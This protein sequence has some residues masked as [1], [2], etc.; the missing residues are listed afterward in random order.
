MKSLM[1]IVAS[2]LL[3]GCAQADAPDSATASNPATA[4]SSVR[5][6]LADSGVTITG[7]L[8]APEGFHGLVGNYRGR[9]LPVYVL[10]DGKHFVVG[11]LYDMQGNDLTSPAM[12][13]A[14][15]SRLSETQWKALDKATWFA[16]G[17][18]EGKR[19]VY[20]FM[21]TECP[22]CHQFWKKSQSWLD[23]GDV[24]MRI[25]LVAV[26]SPK[27]LPN[28]AA[29]LSADDRVAAW[30]KNERQFGKGDAA[31]EAS[32]SADA[33]RKIR[34]NNALMQKL[35]FYGTPSIIYKDTDGR[36]HS[37]QGMPRDEK[38]MR[39]VFEG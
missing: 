9:P 39:A 23:D 12:R 13:T 8:E 1:V 15:E 3:F 22:Y 30:K 10:P 27:S 31:P 16:A 38:G 18:P 2:L 7:E 37:L 26:I 6:A 19:V 25:I 17:N 11:S 21:D 35:G 34:D 5:K 29:L 28:G 20:A 24:Q 4:A 33:L 36:I 14:A 32:P